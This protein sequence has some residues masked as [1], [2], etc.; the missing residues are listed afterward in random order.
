MDLFSLDNRLHYAFEKRPGTGVATAQ[1]WVQVG[2]KHEDPSVAGITHFVEHLIFKGTEKTKGNE[3]AAMIEAMGG[4]GKR[5]HLLRQHGVPRGH[6]F[7]DLRGR[8]GPS[9]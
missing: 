2:S 3:M 5:L 1:V 9:P 6:P 4:L 8:T 7:Q